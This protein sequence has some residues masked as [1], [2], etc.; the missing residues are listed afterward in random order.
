MRQFRD[1]A[2]FFLASATSFALVYFHFTITDLQKGVA[3]LLVL[4]L[5]LYNH[6][7]SRS[8]HQFLAKIFNS[9]FLYGSAVFV[10]LLVLSAGG[11][12]SPFL[13]LLHLYTLGASFLL[14][15]SGG[16]SFLIFSLVVLLASIKIDPAL[17]KIFQDDPGTVLLY[18]ASFSVIVPLSIAISRYYH[19]KGNLFNLL[20]KEFKLSNSRQETV[21]RGVQEL[22]VVTDPNL[23]IVSLNEAA[24]KTFKVDP[25]AALHQ[26]LL[27]T[28]HILNADHQP[29]SVEILQA[30]RV[31][32]DKASRIVDNLFISQGGQAVPMPI[33]IQISPV[34]DAEN[35]VNQ[36]LFVISDATSRRFGGHANLDIA[37]LKNKELIET[38]RHRL[39]LA[40]MNMAVYEVDLF[41][42]TE[43][44]LFTAV[45]LE[46][47]PISPKP[48]Y[49]DLAEICQEMVSSK[50]NFAASLGVQVHFL[51]PE[52]DSSEWALLKLKEAHADPGLIGDSKFSSP[53]DVRW[54]RILVDKLLDLAILLGSSHPNSAVRLSIS[55][56]P[57]G[58]IE[59]AILTTYF[60]A[61]PLMFKF[62]VFKEYYGSLVTSSN[63][64]RGSGLEGFIVKMVAD[65]LRL[66]ILVESNQSLL[67]TSFKIQVGKV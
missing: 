28:L 37:Y 31:L 15:L 52:S 6:A 58:L 56:Q 62:E 46:D 41:A 8:T 66:P 29:I 22:V 34:K 9:L 30:Q 33:S 10:Q 12:Y 63:L 19:L 40:K 53:I 44:D 11:F 42:K 18:L 21:L 27:Q 17:S 59:V 7:R 26:P 54:F 47:H 36:L 64:S 5:V 1:S 48:L 55:R 13:I 45:E 51:L 50:N 3:L 39:E 43:D 60:P 16:I 14:S 2:I 67:Q 35:K 38:L 4:L 23:N 32:V 57:Q 25:S 20:N 61:N 65:Q 49:R 24:Q